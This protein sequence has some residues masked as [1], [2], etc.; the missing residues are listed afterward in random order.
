MAECWAPIPGVSPTI[1]GRERF[2]PGRGR[3]D[4]VMSGEHHPPRGSLRL[5]WSA[6]SRFPP[7]E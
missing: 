5:V 1:N 7:T 6:S 4:S 3:L 2:E